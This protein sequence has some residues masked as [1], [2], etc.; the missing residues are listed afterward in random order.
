MRFIKVIFRSIGSFYKNNGLIHAA[1]ISY[2]SVMAIIPF[3][4]LMITIFGYFLGQDEEL[5]LFFTE[6][7]SSFFPRITYEIVDELKRIITYKGIGQF[8]MI[9]YILLSYQLFSSL[10]TAVNA[11]FKTKTKRTFL[12]SFVI[13]LFMITL[14]SIFIIISFGATTAVSLLRI[15]KNYL[16]GLKIGFLIKF[17]IG[18]AIPFFLLFLTATSLYLFLPRVRVR[19]KSVISGAVFASLLFEAAK[20]L[21]AIYVVEVAR[22]GAIYGP[23]S[24]FVMFLLWVFYS[25]AIFLVGAGIVHNLNSKMGSPRRES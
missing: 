2:F 19:L 6:R 21:F 13:S 11:I 9:L 7:L 14:V 17:L 3:C 1:A 4:L 18:Y 10:E 5:L 12:M 8:T 24:V 15:L 23:L 25:S 16:P 22:L 20:H